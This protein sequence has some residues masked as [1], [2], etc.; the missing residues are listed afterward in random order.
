MRDTSLDLL[1]CPFCGARIAVVDNEALVNRNGMVEFGVLG[2]EC[3][4]FP[5]V[6][7]IPVLIANDVTRRAVRALEAGRPELALQDLLGLHGKRA[8]QF[9]ALLARNT[10]ATYQEALKILSP[11]AEG[12]Y[13]L[14]RFSDPTYLTAEAL[15]R[16]VNQSH[17][18]TTRPVLDLCGGSGHLTRVL[19]NTDRPDSSIARETFVVDLHFWKLWL[20]AV[21]CNVDAPLPFTTD[22]FSIVVLTDAFPY[23]WHKRLCAT[24]IM[25]VTAP[26]GVILLPHL[27]STLGKNVSAGNT[28]TPGG[29][30]DLFTPYNPKLF[31]DATLFEGLLEHQV[32]DLTQG[33][34]PTELGQ[35]PV[36]T[37]V[38]SRRK[39]Y[40][41]RQ[42]V[43]SPLSVTGEL[44][45][46]PL[47]RIKL[48]DGKSILK[49]SFPTAEYEDE[50]G[51]CRRYLP[52]TMTIDADLTGHIEPSMLKVHYE[53]LRRRRVLIDA[54]KFY[55]TAKGKL[56]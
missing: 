32:V 53:E 30:R 23:V 55:S 36:L 17:P 4:A 49:L 41:R 19:A 15:V 56:Q 25:R 33:L 51:T 37:L 7:G 31:N 5:L 9:T 6:D 24:E 26:N 20:A 8:E 40:F 43:P 47:Y 42:S 35:D 21:C 10:R 34:S 54:P 39:D 48:I 1:G 29:Y 22:L 46:N 50:F 2:C 13:F 28:L 18:T 27:H 14:Y 44:M 11:D 12:D 45:V 38:A 16:S 52:D 3:C